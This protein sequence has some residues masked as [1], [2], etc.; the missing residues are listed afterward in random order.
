MPDDRAARAVGPAERRGGC[1]GG[2]GARGEVR[3]AGGIDQSEH[4]PGP[5]VQIRIA[6]ESGC[7][8]AEGS[9]G[10][11]SELHRDCEAVGKPR[12]FA[13]VRG[14]IELSGDAEYPAATAMDGRRI[15]GGARADDGGATDAGGVQTVRAGVLPHG[16]RGLGHGAT[17][18]E[19]RGAERAGAGGH[20]APLPGTEHRA[21]CG[22]AAGFGDAGRSPLQRPAVRGRRSDDGIDRSL[23]GVSY[24]S[25]DSLFR[26][27]RREDSG[28]RV[29]DRPE[30][31]FEGQD[32]SDDPD[33]EDGDGTVCQGVAGGSR[34]AGGIADQVCAGGRGGVPEGRIRNRRTA[35]DS[36]MD[37]IQGTA[38]GSDG[39]LPPEWVPGAN[40]RGPGTAERGRSFELRVARRRR[41]SRGDAQRSHMPRYAF[42]LRIKADAIEEYERE[43]QR[44]WPELL[45]RL[46]AVGISEYS[47][48]RR[49]QELVLSLRVDD[50]ERAWDELDRDAV[51]LRWQEFM[52]RLFEPVPEKQEGE[53]FAMMKE[54]FYLKYG[55]GGVA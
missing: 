47:I 43:H 40:H 7:G 33:G 29:H 28:H 50:L 36:G 37:E 39:C 54:V 14:R 34:E 6:G 51:N 9:A 22:V 32:G 10:S 20:G 27:G 25:R 42:K 12:S 52:S 26:M 46:K 35:G 2:A 55:V 5:G 45:A 8:S 53:R 21:D 18:R 44:V 17:V 16:Y 49:G 19:G 13:V 3:T 1:G 15:E 31:Q 48:F 23:S 41:P 30:P 24:F 11:H 4:V 38:G